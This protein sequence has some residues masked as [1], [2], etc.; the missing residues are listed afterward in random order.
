MDV[1]FIKYLSTLGVGGLIAGLM[2]LVYRKDMARYSEQWKGQSEALMQVVKEN[3]V[4]LTANTATI[5]ALRQS[6]DRILTRLGYRRD[7]H[8]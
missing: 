2:F 3:S 5:Q 1:E 6:D 7:V 8:E 4:A